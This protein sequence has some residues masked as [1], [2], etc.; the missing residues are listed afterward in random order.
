MA[1]YVLFAWITTVSSHDR[2]NSF[3]CLKVTYGCDP[4]FL[5]ATGCERVDGSTL[6]GS[7]PEQL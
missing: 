5:A 7:K 1:L 6:A 4:G 2:N 3:L